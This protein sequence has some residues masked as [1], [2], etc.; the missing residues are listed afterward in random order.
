ML[1]SILDM[2]F[3]YKCSSVVGS[4]SGVYEWVKDKNSV[5]F[6]NGTIIEKKRK[7]KTNVQN[8]TMESVI[9]NGEKKG[10]DKIHR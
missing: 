7:K 9:F 5:Q 4:S 8:I 2:I 1:V 10:V 3:A 6:L